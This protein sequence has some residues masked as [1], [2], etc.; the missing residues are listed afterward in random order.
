MLYAKRHVLAPVERAIGKLFAFLPPN[1]WT[2]LSIIFALIFAFAVSQYMFLAGSAL[3]LATAFLDL[4]DGSVARYTKSATV[5]GAYLDTIADR[6]VEGIVII[7]LLFVGLPDYVVPASLWIFAY[8][9]GSFMTTYAKAAL[10]EKARQEIMGGLLERAERMLILIVGVFLA[11][12]NVDYL[13]Y[14]VIALAILTNISAL[15][16][17]CIGMKNINK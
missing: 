16:R 4:I 6:Y 17:I 2:L 9:F 8:L 12:M 7:S 11:S 14:V 5:K 13:L 1:A 10:A 3:L 15:Q